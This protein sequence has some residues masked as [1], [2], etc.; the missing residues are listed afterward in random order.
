M[1]A[2]EVF[3]RKS[4]RKYEEVKDQWKDEGAIYELAFHAIY[5]VSEEMIVWTNEQSA[6]YGGHGK[7]KKL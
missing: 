3:P 4:E 7:R 6:K 1:K 2:I 5:S